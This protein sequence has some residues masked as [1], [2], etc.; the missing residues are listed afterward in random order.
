MSMAAAY[1]APAA[2]GV[3][4]APIALTKI[5]NDAGKSIPVP[6]AC[7]P[8]GDPRP[9]R[10]AV[11]YILQGV[12]TGA[13]CYRGPR[14]PRRLPGGGQ[15]RHLPNVENGPGTPYAAFAGYT[16]A[17]T[18]YA[19]V[20]NPVS[21]T[22]KDTMAYTQRLLPLLVRLP[23]LPRWRC[24]A[25]TPRC[26]CGTRP[27]TTPT[28]PAPRPSSRCRQAARCGTRATGRW[29]SSHL[30]K[31][32]RAAKGNGN[33]GFPGQGVG[34]T[35]RYRGRRRA[36]RRWRWWRRRRYRGRP[37]SLLPIATP[38]PLPP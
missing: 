33:D 18:G 24:S 5:V 4:C 10:E 13:G 15:D 31:K 17:L 21:P 29:S 20:F 3:Y 12:F 30:P 25:R 36:P 6:S 38:A 2:N 22:V 19:S 32:E 1:A 7:L 27:S 28:C 8:P 16:T 14:G 26:R 35:R 34:D 23:G 37:R 9:G 11:N